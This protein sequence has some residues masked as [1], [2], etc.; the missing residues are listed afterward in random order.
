[1]QPIRTTAQ[2]ATIIIPEGMHLAIKPELLSNLTEVSFVKIVE[3]E[4]ILQPNQSSLLNVIISY[5]PTETSDE[6]V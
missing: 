3:G 6:S 4:L 5:L 2:W 1:M